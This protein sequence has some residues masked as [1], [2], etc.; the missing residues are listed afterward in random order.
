VKLRIKQT[1]MWSFCE[2]GNGTS[3]SIRDR[4]FV[5][6]FSKYLFLTKTSAALD[7]AV[8]LSGNALDFIREVLL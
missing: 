4:K 7:L 8:C 5:A 3:E 2:D 6:E 1:Y